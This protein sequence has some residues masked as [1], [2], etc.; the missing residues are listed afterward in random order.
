MHR[1]GQ[2]D[3]IPAFCTLREKVGRLG[4]AISELYFVRVIPYSS[5]NGSIAF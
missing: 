3:R 4:I 2:F 1:L 5:A